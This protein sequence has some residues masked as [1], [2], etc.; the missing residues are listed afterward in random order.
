MT[1]HFSNKTLVAFSILVTL[2]Y[3]GFS[4]SHPTSITGGYTGAPNDNVCISCHTPGG[5][6]DGM[7]EISGLPSS[8]EANM[9]YPLTVTIT[10]TQGSAVRAGFQMVSLKANLANGGTFSVPATE[11]NAVVKT[12]ALKSYVGHQPAKNFSANVATFDVEWTAPAS[13]D[14]DIT[15]YVGAMIAN[16]ANGNSN[17]KFVAAN[18]STV[19]GTGVD[20]LMGSFS[21]IAPTS[22]FDSNDGTATINVTGGSGNYD[23]QWSNG[24]STATAIMLPGGE[25]SVTV[26]DD[27]NN[28]IVEIVTI[29]SPPILTAGV[30]TQSDATCN[31]DADG[32]AEIGITGG[33]PGYTVDWG[34]GITGDLQNNLI[35]GI[36]NVTVTDQNG[37]TQ[38]LQVTINEP[39]PLVIN[40]IALNDPSCIDSEDGMISVEATGGNGGYTYNWLTNIGIQNEGQISGLIPGEYEVEVIDSEGCTNQTT[41]TLTEPEPI[42]V[43]VSTTSVSCLGGSD[44]TAT[45]DGVDG[46]A[47]YLY[48]WFEVNNFDLI[49]IGSGS[50]ITDLTVGDYQVLVMDGDGCF[51]EQSFQITE[52][53]EAL[54]VQI[55]VTAEP[56][57]GSSDGTLSAIAQGG[58]PD[59]MYLWDTDDTSPVLTNLSSGTY[60]LTVTDMN[61]CTVVDEI[62]LNDI[63]GITLAANDVLNNSCH[64]AAEGAATISASGGTGAYTYDWSNGGTNATESNLSAGE[65]TITVTDEGS[66]TGEITIEITQPEQIA[67]NA[68]LIDINCAG[69]ANGSIQLDASGG[70]GDLTYLWNTGAEADIIEN[71]I[72]GIFSVVITDA[73]DCAV[74]F[75]YVIAEPEAIDV[76]M[77]EVTAPSCPGDANGQII[78]NPV[79]GTGPLSY[80]WSTGD[81]TTVVEELTA[82]DYTLTITDANTCESTFNFT[83]DDP[84]EITTESTTISP[85]C[86][87]SEDASASISIT[88]GSEPYSILW[89]SGDTTLT[90]ENIAAGTYMA[91]VTDSNGCA[92]ETEIMVVAPP[93]IDPNIISTNETSNGLND[94]TAAA[95]P[96]NGQ[97]PYSYQWSTGDTTQ[98]IQN[99]A[100]GTYG[101]TITDAND[102]SVV[103]SAV[104]NNGDCD[105]NLD[106]TT[107]DISC[108]GLM[109]GVISIAVSGAVEPISYQ[110]NNGET[111]SGIDSLGAGTYDVTVT[112]ANNCSVQVTDL[113]IFEPEEIEISTL[114]IQDATTTTSEDG[115]ITISFSGGTGALTVEY[116]DANGDPIGLDNF[117]NLTSGSYGARV[118]DERGCTRFF[119]PFEVGFLSNTAESNISAKI[120]PNPAQHFV[121]IETTQNLNRKPSLFSATGQ[122]IDIETKVIANGYRLDTYALENGIYYVRLMTAKE[123][124]LKKI[125]IAR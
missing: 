105:I 120:Y 92:A 20:P 18:V 9:T 45:A 107:I 64:G 57:C 106:I 10:N 29:A 109:D 67:D 56:N 99:L 91:T 88:G 71:L 24:E 101:V 6:L 7:V 39:T 47:P 35:A 34:N 115:S 68:T 12:V 114:N 108:F 72:P 76:G 2:I 1:R 110:W 66:C 28:Q 104:I 40:V 79:G 75:E 46:T 53:E 119:G 89:S 27:N 50:T 61:G 80:A 11:N 123:M 86:H 54:V 102:C 19:L 49:E 116:T 117:E 43:V 42:D 33:T 94:G 13:A 21:N 4:T 84:L 70:T 31:G 25:N 121:K 26:T 17:D 77:I 41:I 74:E 8:V 37:C 5:S 125:I 100:P 48:T 44:G 73:N 62:I 93:A 30:I 60:A 78:V 16:G 90:L 118:T 124:V 15:L 51:A 122:K 23:Y 55:S 38:T 82:G 52:P 95:N 103:G 14:G 96:E 97:A 58:T 111:G 3:F 85:T 63:E 59:Y 81:T 98:S 32:S 69:A 113:E 65:Y 22:C 83:I 87:D 36:Y 112:D